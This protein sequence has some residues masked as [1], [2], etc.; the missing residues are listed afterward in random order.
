MKENL[1]NLDADPEVEREWQDV[2]KTN[3]PRNPQCVIDWIRAYMKNNPAYYKK[4]VLEARKIFQENS[5][6]G[7]D[8]IFRNLILSGGQQST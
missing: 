4:K 1:F 8:E 6:T 3:V 7:Y 5:I 2:C